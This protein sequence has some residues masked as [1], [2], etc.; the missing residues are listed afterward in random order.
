MEEKRHTYRI[1]FG[2]D[3]IRHRRIPVSFFMS[4]F[5]FIN[6]TKK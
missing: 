5:I 2:F 6:H 1:K 4:F 3:T